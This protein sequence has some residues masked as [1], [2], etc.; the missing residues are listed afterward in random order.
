MCGGSN[1]DH[2]RCRYEAAFHAFQMQKQQ[3]H[4]PSA[5][6]KRDGLRRYS[7]EM[8]P[9]TKDRKRIRELVKAEKVARDIDYHD[10]IL[11]SHQKVNLE[12][13]IVGR[14]CSTNVFLYSWLKGVEYWYPLN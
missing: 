14:A 5:D 10:N 7:G 6:V 2:G 1:H 3:L 13:V 11:S 4:T 12:E 8:Q 9:E